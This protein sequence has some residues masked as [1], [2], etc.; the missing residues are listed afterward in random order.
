VAIDNNTFSPVVFAQK[1]T[2]LSKEKGWKLKQAIKF[3]KKSL[4][5]K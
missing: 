3:L 2:C 5:I 4:G 1:T